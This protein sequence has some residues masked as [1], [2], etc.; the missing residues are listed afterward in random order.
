MAAG[1]GVIESKDRGNTIRPEA[2]PLD[3]SLKGRPEVVNPPVVLGRGGPDA[4][5]YEWV[6]SDEPD[7]PTFEWRDITGNGTQIPM[8]NDDQN[9]GPFDIGFDFPYYGQ[10]YSQ[11]YV[12]SNGWASFTSTDAVYFNSE[13][14]N[15]DAPTDMLAPFWDDLIPQ[16]AANTGTT[17]TATNW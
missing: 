8:S 12:C 6:D 7:G 10:T 2:P 15:V 4:F 16:V 17:P 9:L 1:A 14:P 5:G 11:F 13:L 3:L